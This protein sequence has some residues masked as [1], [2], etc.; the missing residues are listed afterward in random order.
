MWIDVHT[1]LDRY[2]DEIDSAL[3]QINTSHI[4]SICNSMDPESHRTGLNIAKRSPFVRPAF[5]VHPWN[6]PEVFDDLENIRV[7]A[8]QAELLGETGL[9]HC[10]VTDRH[11]YPQQKEIF[12]C[13]LLQAEL[14]DK[15]ISI[16]S[17]GA[18]REVL[19][20]LQRHRVKRAIL[21]WYSGPPEL[22]P[23]FIDYGCYFSVGPA[24]LLSAGFR[25]LVEKIPQTRLLS[26][27]DNPGGYHS[28]CGKPG[29]P[30]LIKEVVQALAD[31]HRV[32]LKYEIQLIRENFETLYGPTPAVLASTPVL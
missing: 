8:A 14:G 32:S 5:G 16:H 19:T 23:A 11:A 26:E 17:K 12:N 24:V 7:L 4:V 25:A 15:P 13:F 27:T 21:H 30:I 9:D 10:F 29:W 28:L 22:L 1:H 20:A 31:L 2:D 18:E 3:A 6:A